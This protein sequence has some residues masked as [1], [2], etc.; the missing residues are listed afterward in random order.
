MSVS[1]SGPTKKYRTPKG[2]ANAANAR[3]M[4][5]SPRRAGRVDDPSTGIGVAEV[6]AGMYFENRP[7]RARAECPLSRRRANRIRGG[8]YPFCDVR[9]GGSPPAIMPR[10][11]DATRMIVLG[12]GTDDAKLL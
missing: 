7:T 4:I 6:A 12:F 3:Q 9:A 10:V 1:G 8:G 11:A 2:R 5:A